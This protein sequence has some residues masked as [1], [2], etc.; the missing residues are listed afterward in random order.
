MVIAANTPVGRETHS[1]IATSKIE[2]TPY[3]SDGEQVGKIQHLM[4]VSESKRGAQG[5][6]RV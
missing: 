5:R 4:I 2:G 6:N 3:R 1:L